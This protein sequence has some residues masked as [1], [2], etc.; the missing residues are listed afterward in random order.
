MQNQSL[1]MSEGECLEDGCTGT[2]IPN[3]KHRLLSPQ[4]SIPLFDKDI[5]HNSLK[6]RL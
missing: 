2:T 6:D 5:I 3:F 4:A 1:Q